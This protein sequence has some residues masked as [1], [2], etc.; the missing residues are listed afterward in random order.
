MVSIGGSGQLNKRMNLVAFSDVV[1]QF[2]AR[3]GDGERARPA[4]AMFAVFG[5]ARAHQL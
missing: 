4:R 1:Q 3:Q 5:L 2:L